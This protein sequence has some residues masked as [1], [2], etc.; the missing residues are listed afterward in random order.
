MLATEYKRELSRRAEQA[1]AT[2]AHHL[3]Q[4]D[5]ERLADISQGYVS[6]VYRG[7]S[8]PSPQFVALL[9]LLAQDPS[10]LNW[11]SRYWAEPTMQPSIA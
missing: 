5:L 4:A 7:H 9:A 8:A 3:S 6:R 2:L 11:L 10:L 1:I